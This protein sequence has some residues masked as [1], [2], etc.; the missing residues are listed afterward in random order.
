M[1]LEIFKYIDRLFGM[2]RPRNVLYM[3]IGFYFYFYLK[4]KKK[5]QN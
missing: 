2:A 4:K 1:M 5:K 3:A